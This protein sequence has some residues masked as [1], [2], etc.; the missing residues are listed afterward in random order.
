MSAPRR[1]DEIFAL[2]TRGVI[3][4]GQFGHR[5]PPV[6]QASR[7]HAARQTPRPALVMPK[8]IDEEGRGLP[9]ASLD[10]P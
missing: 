4:G 10:R 2:A 8:L 7:A 5:G 3:A 6:Q 9:A 1:I